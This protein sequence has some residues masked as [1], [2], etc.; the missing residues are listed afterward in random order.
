MPY[1]E[2]FLR[3]AIQLAE[4]KMAAGKGGPFGAGSLRYI[5]IIF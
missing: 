5:L 4:D 2:S 3:D 1:T